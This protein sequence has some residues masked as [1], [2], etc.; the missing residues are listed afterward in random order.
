MKCPE[1]GQWNRASMPH[2]AKCGAPLNIDQASKLQWKDTLKDNV[3]STAYLRADEFGQVSNTPDARDQLAREMQDLKLRKQE[4]A[5]KQNRLRK[6]D[7]RGP[8]EVVVTEEPAVR[9]RR[10]RNDDVPLTAVRVQPAD[11]NAQTRRN[12][13]EIWHK[14]RYMDQN[15]AFAESRTYDPVPSGQY[16]Q[17]TGSWYLAGPLG[18]HIAPRK[19]RKISLLN[20]AIILLV[21][22]VIGTG[23]YFGYQYVFAEKA[24]AFN[25]DAVVTAVIMTDDLPGHKILIPG[26][27]GTTIYIPELHASYVVMDGFATIEV[28]DHTW[29]DNLDGPLDERMDIILR[30]FLKTASGKQTPLA[31]VSYEIKIPLSPITLES[32]DSLRTTV[33]TQ[34]KAIQIK[35]RPGSTV[36][37]NGKDYSDI[38][39]TEGEMSYTATVQPSGDNFYIF[40]V[41]SRYC[42]ENTMTVVLYREKQEVMLDLADTTYSST[43]E[44]TMKILAKTEAGARVNVPTHHSDLD[45]TNLDASGD[46]SFYAIFDKIGD[47]RIT[48]EATFGDRKPSIVNH[49]VYYCPPQNEYTPKAWPMDSANYSELLSNIQVRAAE[50]RIYVIKGVVQSVQSEKPQRVIVFSGEDG[51][52]QPVLLENKTKIKK[53][54]VGKYYEFYADAYSTFNSMP[55]LITRYVY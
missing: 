43:S 27:D 22:V 37:V 8:S 15:G 21:L 49:D 18:S 20:I 45:T 10:V 48:I 4:G 36:T 7:G 42:R 30:P 54:E 13:S 31:P 24:P 28:A 41:R 12:E 17:G 3:P 2:C 14:V 50:N 47:N 5:E 32:P 55:W 25:Q 23:G 52:S 6:K 46:F 34:I 29:Y 9:S 53:W 35:V 16:T 26:E 11:R 39:N 44:K 19:V 33:S 38:I 40:S 1:C 51:K